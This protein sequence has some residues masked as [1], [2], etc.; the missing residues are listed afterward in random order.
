[1]VT[2]VENV[3]ANEHL[4]VEVTETVCEIRTNPRLNPKF[5]LESFQ[6]MPVSSEQPNG[7]GMKE[8]ELVH[9]KRESPVK[10]LSDHDL[11][12]PVA[13]KGDYLSDFS[14]MREKSAQ[15]NL[16]KLSI[17]R[18]FET[19]ISL[20]RKGL[21]TVK[22]DYQETVNGYEVPSQG[23]VPLFQIERRHIEQ[24]LIIGETKQE[25]LIERK[26]VVTVHHSGSKLKIKNGEL[27]SQS[28][29]NKTASTMR[30]D[31]LFK[32]MD[33]Q[34]FLSG[35]LQSQSRVHET[36]SITQTESLVK[37]MDKQPIKNGDL[38]GQSELVETVA[39]TQTESF[40]EG[41][42]KQPTSHNQLRVEVD[43][44]LIKSG[45]IQGQSKVSET[46]SISQTE[47]FIKVISKQPTS[48]SQS[49]VLGYQS[50]IND[51]KQSLNK[52]PEND[53]LSGA[54]LIDQNQVQAKE[55]VTITCSDAIIQ[56]SDKK[57][58]PT[59]QIGDKTGDENEDIISGE[60]LDKILLNENPNQEHNSRTDKSKTSN[61]SFPEADPI[62]IEGRYSANSRASE[63]IASGVKS[64][65]QK[66]MVK[67][68]INKFQ[69]SSDIM[70]RGDDGLSQEHDNTISKPQNGDGQLSGAVKDRQPSTNGLRNGLAGKQLTRETFSVETVEI[71]KEVMSP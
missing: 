60:L 11:N 41:I 26:E 59:V 27:Q 42:S 52:N 39:I 17:E 24:D 46:S 61:K 12:E 33:E 38:Q 5:K 23:D 9:D 71:I 50:D 14:T 37:V 36:A 2:D 30:T 3:D 51:P 64:D 57:R 47:S 18:N 8:D 70:P 56:F 65:D 29:I 55:F 32:G 67:P 10:P 7:S 35:D 28:Q 13:P 22:N 49:K 45:D 16:L 19:T 34:P 63:T 15:D 31:S 44:Q 25:S 54:N 4:Y 1:M 53:K 69:S 21:K 20:S 6:R 48:H 68:A 40:I 43:K 58:R 66:S 62:L